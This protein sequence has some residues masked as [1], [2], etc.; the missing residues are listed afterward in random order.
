MLAR[1]F[2]WNQSLAPLRIKAMG[3][4]PDG[5]AF[6]TTGYSPKWARPKQIHQIMVYI[7]KSVPT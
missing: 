4:L 7:A 5:P 2:V 3:L 1:S 6:P